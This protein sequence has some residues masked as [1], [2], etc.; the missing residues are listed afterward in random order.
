M[1][2][3]TK[4]TQWLKTAQTLTRGRSKATNDVNN[5][6]VC[7]FLRVV[8]KAISNGKG[9]ANENLQD[10]A[11]TNIFSHGIRIDGH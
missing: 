4:A 2:T 3:T 10:D 1:M 8:T 7:I 6:W 11:A 5:N 9:N